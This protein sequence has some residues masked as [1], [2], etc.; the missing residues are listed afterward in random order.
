MITFLQT[1]G[2][3]HESE[4]RK[5][6]K[7]V[8][9]LM[10]NGHARESVATSQQPTCHVALVQKVSQLETAVAGRQILRESLK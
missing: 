7:L 3:Y 5:E 6:Y 2:S 8:N 9:S 1:C 10:V 4:A